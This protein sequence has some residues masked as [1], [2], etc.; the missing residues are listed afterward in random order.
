MQVNL[1]TVR[2]MLQNLGREE[3]KSVLDQTRAVDRI[4]KI[5]KQKLDEV[6]DKIF[7][8]AFADIREVIG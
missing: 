1:S 6:Y 5:Y 2:F 4:E 3:T 8:Q 7:E